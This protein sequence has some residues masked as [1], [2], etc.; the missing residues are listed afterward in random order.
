MGD[1]TIMGDGVYLKH[2]GTLYIYNNKFRFK[3]LGKKGCG[4]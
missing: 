4:P 3:N 2:V 1:S